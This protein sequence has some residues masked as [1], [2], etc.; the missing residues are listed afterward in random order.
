MKT[1]LIITYYWP[2]SGGSGVQRWLKFTRYLGSF[3][4]HPVVLTPET[5]QFDSKDSSLENEVH[6]DTEVLKLPIWEP[7]HLVRKLKGEKQPDQGST[8][9]TTSYWM[10]RVRGNLILP[11]PRIFWKTPAVRFLKEY[12]KNRPVDAIITTG[13]PHS[14]HLIGRSIHRK[15]GIPWLVD[16]RDP[17]STWD[18]L[19]EFHTGKLARN[20]HG[21]LER[22]VVRHANA[23]MTVSDTW[24]REISD[25]YNKPVHVIT[26]GFDPVDFQDNARQ[27][28]DKFRLMHFGLINEFRHTPVFWEA[29]AETVAQVPE[30]KDVLEVY[31]R[32]YG[33]IYPAI[34]KDE[35]RTQWIKED[36]KK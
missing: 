4:W 21:K 25:R 22:S 6:A 24:A 33:L 15:L 29:L 9:T 32:P 10:K 13:P 36:R 1:V 27:R 28:P 30:M 5:P 20:Y 3:G 19:E 34:C 11:D 23:V 14:M 12:L 17:W 7:Y 31:P 16:F 18:M 8:S 35:Q 2:P 26:N